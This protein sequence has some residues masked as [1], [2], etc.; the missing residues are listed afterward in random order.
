M[1]L[2]DAQLFVPN[3]DS[4]PVVS[5]SATSFEV[6]IPFGVEV[7]PPGASDARVF[8]EGTYMR[9]IFNS[10]SYNPGKGFPKNV[11]HVLDFSGWSFDVGV[12]FPIPKA[13]K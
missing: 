2:Q 7:G 11:P 3:S 9:R 12:S 8:L 13:S 1:S 10:V 6:G 4:V 5:L